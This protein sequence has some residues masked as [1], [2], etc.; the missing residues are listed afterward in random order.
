[1]R[2]QPR[3]IAKPRTYRAHVCTSRK[4]SERAK[5]YIQLMA[6]RGGAA[7]SYLR[8]RESACTL[9]VIC[10]PYQMRPRSF[11][12]AP[13]RVQRT[14]FFRSS[15][16][17]LLLGCSFPA[18][19]DITGHPRQSR[20]PFRSER[21]S[22]IMYPQA[23]LFQSALESDRVGKSSREYAADAFGLE[24]RPAR[25]DRGFSPRHCVISNYTSGIGIVQY[26]ILEYFENFLCKNDLS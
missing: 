18:L 5:P 19:P 11:H 26:F 7:T 15:S 16:P 3:R 17:L 1:M 22:R 14:P 4:A 2:L 9:P 23:D 6:G 13:R 24:E 20:N 10:G 8:D 12:L 21:P 25:E